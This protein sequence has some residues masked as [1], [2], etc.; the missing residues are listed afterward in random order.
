MAAG[1]SSFL[2]NIEILFFTPPITVLRIL[3]FNF[4]MFACKTVVLRNDLYK[5]YKNC[6]FPLGG[7]FISLPN[8]TYGIGHPGNSWLP[9]SEY[10]ISFAGPELGTAYPLPRRPPPCWSQ[11]GAGLVRGFGCFWR[12]GLARKACPLLPSWCC[13]CLPRA[14]VSPLSSPSCLPGNS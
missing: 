12:Q 7:E 5:T 11:V 6:I 2:C 4:I 3:G 10:K 1:D 14:P 9:L 8:L 13:L